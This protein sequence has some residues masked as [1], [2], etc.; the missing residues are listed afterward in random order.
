M[1]IVTTFSFGNCDNEYDADVAKAILEVRMEGHGKKDKKKTMIFPKLVFM[2]H[3]DKH[4]D[5]CEFEW[6]FDVSVKCSSK[7]MYPD[8]IGKGHRREGKYVSPMG[9]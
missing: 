8:Y 4:S 7:C 6:L 5:G 3:E 9:E 2:H 1:W